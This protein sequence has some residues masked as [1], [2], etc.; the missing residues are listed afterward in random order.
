M[1]IDT[2]AVAQSDPEIVGGAPVFVGTRVPIQR[3]FDHL[4]D[5]D[6]L[7][8][9]LDD[10]PSVLRDQAMAALEMAR[11][12]LADAAYGG[13]SSGRGVVH[14]DPEILGGAPVF[15]GTRVPVQTLTDHLAAGYDIEAIVD[16]FPTLS[17]ERAVAALD[18]AQDA[19]LTA[20]GAHARPAR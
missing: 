1:A 16:Q 3:L 5:G 4:K 12:A 20:A 9:F 15:V 7:Q 2:Q 13:A 8:V 18:L 10:F 6:R 19:L 11:A 14:S 17:R